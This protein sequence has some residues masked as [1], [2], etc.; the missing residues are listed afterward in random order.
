MTIR[1]GR[2]HTP[3]IGTYGGGRI[4]LMADISP[5]KGAQIPGKGHQRKYMSLISSKI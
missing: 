4:K 2:R 1:Q 5:K 3:G